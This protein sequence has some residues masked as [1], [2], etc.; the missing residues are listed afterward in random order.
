ML[1]RVA[2]RV[3]SSITETHTYPPTIT[4]RFVLFLYPASPRYPPSILCIKISIYNCFITS[5]CWWVKYVGDAHRRFKFCGT[6]CICRVD[7]FFLLCDF[8]RFRIWV[9][10]IIYMGDAHRRLCLCR[11]N[12]SCVNWIFAFG[13]VSFKQVLSLAFTVFVTVYL[14]SIM[15]P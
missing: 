12:L 4:F 10:E 13:F 9:F 6:I 8:N 5:L 15:E 7:W 2:R 1:G 14:F 11:T 3:K